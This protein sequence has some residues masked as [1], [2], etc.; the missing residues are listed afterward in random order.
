MKSNVNEDG[1]LGDFETPNHKTLFR[2]LLA[3]FARLDGV[4]VT[5]HVVFQ[6]HGQTG[7]TSAHRADD[8][9]YRSDRSGHPQPI[10]WKSVHPRRITARGAFLEDWTIFESNDPARSNRLGGL[11][12]NWV[13]TRGDDR[14]ECPVFRSFSKSEMF[15]LDSQMRIGISGTVGR[16]GLLQ[17]PKMERVVCS[18]LGPLGQ[19]QLPI[20]PKSVAGNRF[21][22]NRRLSPVTY[23][24]DGPQS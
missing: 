6:G 13:A 24:S 17:E 19:L 22:K 9:P 8:D 3:G 12:A 5:L 18:S 10:D 15:R 16:V 20:F 11:L 21:W 23:C 4:I 2:R 14:A 1:G 7:L